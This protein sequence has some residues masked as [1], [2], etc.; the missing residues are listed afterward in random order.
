MYLCIMNTIR[1]I[2]NYSFKYK[3][4]AFL[5]I[6]GN[7]L[8]TFFNL[9]SLVLFIPFLQLIFSSEK[10][11]TVIPKPTY[12]GDISLLPEF[13]IKSYNFQMHDMVI[14]DPKQALFSVCIMVFSA[15]FLKNL[16]RYMAIWFQSEL[17]FSVVR[18]VRDELFEKSIHLP[19]SFHTQERK[20]DLI[21]RM[22]SDVGEIENGVVALLEILFRDPISIFIHIVSLFYISPALTLA[23]FFLLPISAFVIS[24]VGKSLKRTAQQNQ[25]Q[26]GLLISSID[27]SLSGVRIIKSFNA[28]GFIF[29]L[30]KKLNLRHQKLHTKTMRKK[31]VSSLLNETIG[32][33]VMMCLVW[34]GGQEILDNTN[35]GLTGEL[36]LTFIII[37]SQ[38]LRPIQSIS[39]GMALM[40][41]AKVSLDRVNEVLQTDEKITEKPNAKTIVDFKSKISF[42]NISFKYAEETIISSFSLEVKKGKLI[43]IVGESG[44]GKSTLMDL[45]PRFYDVN[46]GSIL[47][48]EVDIRDYKIA[49]LRGLIGIVSQESIL[50]NISVLENIAFGDPNPD[51][52]RVIEAAKIAN[53]HGFISDMDEA[54]DSIV[55][56]RG[57]KL[58]G[59]QKQRLSIARAVYKNPKILILDEATSALDTESEML[60][61]EALEKLMQNRTSFVIAH[62]LSTVRN[63][64][65]IIVLAKGEIIE[66]GN[67]EDLMKKR[68]AYQKFCTL[69]GLK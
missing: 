48:D 4:L 60:V 31:D 39:N 53:A 27:E 54:Y 37:F 22:S 67:H 28:S 26:L 68:G 55:G 34:F 66:Q 49:D 19:L 15:F 14:H 61:Q 38:L 47:I 12:S 62:R 44:S 24:R 42:E 23:S 9:L 57:N 33:G 43:A 17:R 40:N 13:I 7:L 45:L 16:F 10:L 36:F 6:I 64:D 30:F 69:Q 35:N 5:T 56:E 21:S 1:Q 2:F 8:F 18:D 65:E 25:E 20:G 63:A 46:E 52:N 3:K 51:R 58:S 59:G 50:F 11:Q 41:K 32:A 29:N